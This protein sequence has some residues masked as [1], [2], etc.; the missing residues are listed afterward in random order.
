MSSICCSHEE[1]CR[2]E[3]KQ[4]KRNKRKRAKNNLQWHWEMEPGDTKE[5][6]ATGGNVHSG[7]GPV[8]R[9]GLHHCW[10]RA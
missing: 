5:V 3:D 8:L 6:V 9:E 1:S 2:Q 10:Q 7:H 4:A